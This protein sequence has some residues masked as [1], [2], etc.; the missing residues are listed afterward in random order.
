[1]LLFY[2]LLNVVSQARWV[3]QLQGRYALALVFGLM[4]CAWWMLNADFPSTHA[5]VDD[6]YNHAKYFLVFIAGFLLARQDLWWQQLVANRRLWLVIALCCYCLIIAERN[7]VFDY[8]SGPT[9]SETLHNMLFGSVLVIN[10]WVWLLAVLGYA[11]AYL[12]KTNNPLLRYCNDAVLPWYILH[13]TLII[14]FAAWLKPLAIPAVAEFPLLLALTV[15]A[16][17]L[18]YELIR[19]VSL[20]RWCFGLG[21]ARPTIQNSTFSESLSEA[22]AVR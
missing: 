3:Q 5:L 1:M 17:W 11:G 13:Q 20:L 9:K 4:F 6:W 8:Y 15:A 7:D 18:G 10:H 14:L 12:A 2:P 22:G 19:R 21:K 16:C